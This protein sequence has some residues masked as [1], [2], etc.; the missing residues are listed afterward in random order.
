[1]KASV[2]AAT[3]LAAGL[4]TVSAGHAQDPSDATACWRR[5]G[6]LGID[7][8]RG[9]MRLTQQDDGTMHTRFFSEPE[10][11]TVSGP[12]ATVLRAGDVIVAVDTLAITTPAGGIRFSTIEPGEA[13]T[14]A[15]RRDG[16]VRS[17]PLT[18]GSR[19]VQQPRRPDVAGVGEGA[20]VSRGPGRALDAMPPEVYVGFSFRC[21]NCGLRTEGDSA[22]WFFSSPLEVTD[23]QRASPAWQ[24][25]LRP[26]DEIVSVGGFA[27]GSA[28][29]GRAFTRL[30]PGD[31]VAIGWRRPDGGTHGGTLVPDGP[32]TGPP[33][34][35]SGAGAGDGA[36]RYA[37]VLDRTAIEVRGRP[38]IVTR[39]EAVGEVTIQAEGILV[40]LRRLVAEP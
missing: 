10:V 39:D 16:R 9:S 34:G 14:L 29:A 4:A 19:C 24:T 8:I 26:G 23:V 35:G 22:V 28:A 7:G 11:L 37:G 6:D 2:F 25:G 3:V 31:P 38:V 32:R 18:A 20:G 30:R 1:M 5:V 15:F 13:V 36:L 12:A 40:T 17:A 33:A 27:V 21:A